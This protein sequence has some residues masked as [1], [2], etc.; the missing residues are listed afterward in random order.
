MYSRSQSPYTS[1][2]DAV[3]L[4]IR[5]CEGRLDFG[6]GAEPREPRLKLGGVADGGNHDGTVVREF[7]DRLIF[8]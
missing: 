4:I 8:A 3:D 2:R 1:R 7:L 6:Q 5:W